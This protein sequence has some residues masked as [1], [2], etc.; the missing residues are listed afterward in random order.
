MSTIKVMKKTAKPC[1]HMIDYLLPTLRTPHCPPCFL[2]YPILI[3]NIEW[4]DCIIYCL[5]RVR[6][7]TLKLVIKDKSYKMNYK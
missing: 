3:I 1:L 4:F 5:Y 7:R 2:F 6:K